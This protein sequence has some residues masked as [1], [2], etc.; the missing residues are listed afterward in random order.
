MAVANGHAQIKL[1]SQ[2]TAYAP[3]PADGHFVISIFTKAQ[4]NILSL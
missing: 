1:I 3:A 4:M 2:A